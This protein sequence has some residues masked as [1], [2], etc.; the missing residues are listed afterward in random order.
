MSAR[1]SR[2]STPTPTDMEPRWQ[3]PPVVSAGTTHPRELHLKPCAHNVEQ[4]KHL[5]NTPSSDEVWWI[6]TII[7]KFTRPVFLIFKKKCID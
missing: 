3:H 6:N 4:S 1:L 2:D 7:I 5:L